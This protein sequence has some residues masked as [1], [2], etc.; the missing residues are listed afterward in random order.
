M[1]TS[2]SDQ[3]K[4]TL[5]LNNNSCILSA[6]KGH[7]GLIIDEKSSQCDVFPTKGL[8]DKIQEIQE[9][10]YK[11][12]S[13]NTFFKKSQKMEIAKTINKN[14]DLNI[15]LENSVY[16]IPIVSSENKQNMIFIDYPTLKKFIHKDIYEQVTNY[17]LELYNICIQKYGNYIIYVNLDSFTI[18]AAE[19]YKDAIILFTQKCFNENINYQDFVDKVYI[20]N[21][22]SNISSVIQ[23]LKPFFPKNFFDRVQHYTK[24]ESENLMNQWK[25]QIVSNEI[26][27]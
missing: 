14:I 9:T 15:L 2:K 10:Y 12:Q 11:Q 6:M 16:I 13:K 23:M 5:S 4:I 26:T 7:H 1:N 22:P 8:I 3:D 21:T 19:R 20:L 25:M 24:D 27:V 17:V 18:S